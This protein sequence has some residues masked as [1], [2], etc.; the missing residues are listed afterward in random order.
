MGRLAEG[1]VAGHQLTFF[2]PLNQ[3]PS[4]FP[5]FLYKISNIGSNAP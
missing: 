4:F 3:S 2:P 1:G 5:I